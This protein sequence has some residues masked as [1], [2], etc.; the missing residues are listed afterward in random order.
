MRPLRL[1]TVL[2]ATDLDPASDRALETG[3]RLATAAG[4]ALHVVHVRDSEPPGGAPAA[5]PDALSAEIGDV[6]QRA[7]VSGQ[8]TAIHVIPGPA[9]SAIRDLAAAIHADV[10][11]VGPHRGYQG[12]ERGH[13]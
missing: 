4:A 10:I 6:L 3:R 11:I 7:G 13:R 1:I 2:V 12:A 8:K 5:S 9:A